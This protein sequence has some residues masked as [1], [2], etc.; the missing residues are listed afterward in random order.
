MRSDKGKIGC[1]ALVLLALLVA[2]IYLGFKLIPP[3]WEYYSLREAAR[4]GVV[5]ASAPPYRDG[6]AKES[7]IEKAKRL[8]VPL[9]EG[10]LVFSRDSKSVSLE[11]SWERQ[12]PL[13]GR[14][15]HFSFTVRDSEP[16]H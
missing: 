15:Q 10:D 7:V 1:G 4:Q 16:I 6:D 3:Y 8:G 11:F 9:G 12:V 5:S 2:G 14:T 13:P